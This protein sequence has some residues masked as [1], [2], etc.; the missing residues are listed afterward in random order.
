L[1][2][3]VDNS[4][5][6]LIGQRFGGLTVISEGKT[7]GYYKYYLCKCDCGN[8]KE[9]YEANLRRGCSNSRI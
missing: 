6:N 2:T 7:R 1:K 9:I 4:K 8:E 5:A 3:R